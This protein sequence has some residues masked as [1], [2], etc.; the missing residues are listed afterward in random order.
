ME[1]FNG[2]RKPVKHMT[3]REI[4]EETLITLRAT[5]NLV[6][7]FITNFASNPM[8]GTLTKMFGR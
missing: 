8:F 6:E 4:A 7:N 5:Q 1:H 3:D 2:E